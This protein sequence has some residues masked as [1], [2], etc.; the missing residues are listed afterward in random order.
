MT[1]RQFVQTVSYHTFNI[2]FV[3]L[4]SSLLTSKVTFALSLLFPIKK[5]VDRKVCRSA[6]ATQPTNSHFPP[7]PSLIRLDVFWAST[8]S[9]QVC[10]VCTSVCTCECAS[11]CVS[12]DCTCVCLTP[13][14]CRTEL[15]SWFRNS[16]GAPE[17]K[18]RG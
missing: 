5:H 2:S 16:W 12:V 3:I 14:P 13:P 8:I 4:S 9:F 18:S 1:R 17:S 11:M 6:S 15:T 7:L 10:C